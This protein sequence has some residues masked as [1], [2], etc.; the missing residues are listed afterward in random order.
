[1]LHELQ[2]ER[3]GNRR[4]LSSDPPFQHTR[5]WRDLSEL[6]LNQTYAPTSRK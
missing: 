5:D 6:S 3:I 2:T 1:M 4:F